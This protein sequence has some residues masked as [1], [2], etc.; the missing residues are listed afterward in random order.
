MA[1]YFPQVKNL[2]SNW[3]D[4][5]RKREKSVLAILTLNSLSNQLLLC[6]LVTAARAPIIFCKQYW[7]CLLTEQSCLL[8]IHCSCYLRF[9]GCH[10]YSRSS[11]FSLS[12]VSE[13]FHDTLAL[14]YFFTQMWGTTCSFQNVTHFTPP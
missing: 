3:T 13:A 4:L 6:N 1:S 5:G 12:A 2:S 14:P 11:P 10:T 9:N 7:S 8:T